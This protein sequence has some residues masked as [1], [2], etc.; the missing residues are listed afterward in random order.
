M[1]PPPRPPRPRP[2]GCNLRHSPLRGVCNAV[3]AG[4]DLLRK[5]TPLL[6]IRW[7]RPTVGRWF[8]TMR[9]NPVVRDL[10]GTALATSASWACPPA[11]FADAPSAWS[12]VGGFRAAGVR[13]VSGTLSCRGGARGR[14]ALPRRKFVVLAPPVARDT[15]KKNGGSSAAR[16][17]GSSAATPLRTLLWIWWAMPPPTAALVCRSALAP[18]PHVAPSRWGV[19]AGPAQC[20]LPFLR[21]GIDMV[22]K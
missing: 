8:L 18:H 9:I 16:C 17:G 4:V 21:R 2:G 15:P 10:Q 7:V 20:P 5:V 14:H 1:G 12:T 13:L 11:P 3:A 19:Y 22:F 6:L